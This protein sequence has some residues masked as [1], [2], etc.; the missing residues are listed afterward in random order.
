MKTKISNGIGSNNKKN[1][2]KEE[3]SRLGEICAN[4]ELDKELIVN[5]QTHQ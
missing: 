2:G 3:H 4:H 1:T 5:I